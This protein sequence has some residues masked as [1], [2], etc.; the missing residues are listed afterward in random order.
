[1][2]SEWPTP[3]GKKAA[4]T[5]EARIASSEFHD[6]DPGDEGLLKMPRA[7]KPLTRVWWQISWM[8]SQ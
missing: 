8:A 3:W 7:W 5:P 4:L 6:P 2:P 1:M